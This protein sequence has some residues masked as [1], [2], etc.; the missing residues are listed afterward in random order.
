MYI[1]ACS[2]NMLTSKEQVVWFT[3]YNNPD[4]S[5]DYVLTRNTTKYSGNVVVAKK[6]PNAC[7]NTYMYAI[8][9]SLDHFVNEIEE[10]HRDDWTYHSVLTEDYRYIYFDID[11]KLDNPLSVDEHRMYSKL[12]LQSLVNFFRMY[13]N[14][15]IEEP[16]TCLLYTSPSPRDH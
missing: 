3:Y 16:M 11:C 13:G 8:F 2:M 4:V 5:K 9:D 10:Q 1:D 14:C 15:L 6:V 12:I 7:K